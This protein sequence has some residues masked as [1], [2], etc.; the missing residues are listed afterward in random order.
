MY[1]CMVHV[2]HTSILCSFDKPISKDL[3]EQF[4]RHDDKNR[5][6]ARL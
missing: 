6:A 5:G 4:A 1:F 2:E 3:V